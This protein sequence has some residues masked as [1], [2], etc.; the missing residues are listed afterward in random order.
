MIPASHPRVDA[1]R[2]CE[3][4]ARDALIVLPTRLPRRP[5]PGN[6]RYPATIGPRMLRTPESYG[7]TRPGTPGVG[8][9]N[10]RSMLVVGLSARFGNQIAFSLLRRKRNAYDSRTTSSG[11]LALGNALACVSATKPSMRPTPTQ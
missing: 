1:A 5:A 6:E 9:W 7:S 2:R 11:K 8:Q 3:F 10:W 4:A